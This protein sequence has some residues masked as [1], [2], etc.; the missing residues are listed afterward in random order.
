M[1][2][3]LNLVL[4]G[5]TAIVFILFALANRELVRISLSPDELNFFGFNFHFYLPLFVVFFGG[6]IFGIMIGFVLEW[7][8]EYKLRSASSRKTRELKNMQSQLQQLKEEKYENLDEVLALLDDTTKEAKRSA[9][10]M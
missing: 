3:A 8:R 9:P 7:M 4:S 6:A 1:L 2:R 5:V 10:L